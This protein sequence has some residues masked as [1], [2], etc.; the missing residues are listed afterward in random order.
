MKF[1]SDINNFIRQCP[2]AGQM[3]LRQIAIALNERGFTTPR[4]GQWSA[5]QVK[6]V[7]DQAGEQP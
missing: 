5:V 6:R 7:I 1:A 4:G 2:M 3:S